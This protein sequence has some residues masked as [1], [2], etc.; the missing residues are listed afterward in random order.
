MTAAAFDEVPTLK[1]LIVHTGTVTLPLLGDNS[2]VNQS[3][4]TASF[5]LYVLRFHHINSVTFPNLVL[6]ELKEKERRSTSFLNVSS[7]LLFD[8]QIYYIM[9]PSGIKNSMVQ[10]VNPQ[11]PRWSMTI[12]AKQR[13]VDIWMNT[14]MGW[15]CS[16]VIQR[17]R[18]EAI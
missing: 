10:M 15:T 17:C 1:L 14:V 12:T 2:S 8:P 16:K 3:Q 11:E 5:T 7:C 6:R 4:S 18:N 9:R 13:S